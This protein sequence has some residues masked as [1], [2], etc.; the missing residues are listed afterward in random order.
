MNEVFVLLILDEHNT[1]LDVPVPMENSEQSLPLQHLTN[2]AKNYHLV[3]R[4]SQDQIFNKFNHGSLI[5]CV[6]STYRN[7]FVGLSPKWTFSLIII[8]CLL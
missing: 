8:R 4:L 1:G 2:V 3:I 5:A 7:G 6:T